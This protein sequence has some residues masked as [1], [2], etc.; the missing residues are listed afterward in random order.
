MWKKSLKYNRYIKRRLI[1]LFHFSFFIFHFS[2]PQDLWTN[3]TADNL[4]KLNF[5]IGAFQASRVGLTDKIEVKTN[6]LHNIFSQNI[7]F[8]F[9]WWERNILIATNHDLNYPKLG[10]NVAQNTNFRKWIGDTTLIPKTL[11]LKNELLISRFFKRCE[12][13]AN[14]FLVT[15]KFGIL[16]NLYHNDSVF[17]PIKQPLL[18]QRTEIFNNILS[19]NFGVDFQGP[20]FFEWLEFLVDMDYYRIFATNT[21]TLEHKLMV[22]WKYSERINFFGGYKIAYCSNYIGRNF[23]F[24]PLVDAVYIFNITPKPKNGLFKGRLNR[25]LNRMISD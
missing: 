3:E 4:D 1:L 10:L 22:R 21:E 24:F 11:T 6:G 16:M 19:W 18:Y 9:Q 13:C 23:L 17:Q 25:R 20:L 8:K 12:C 5:R 2:F 7:A 15:Y 14:V